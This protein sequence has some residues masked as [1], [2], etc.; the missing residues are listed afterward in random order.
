MAAATAAAQQQQQQ[1]QQHTQVLHITPTGTATTASP[2]QQSTQ[3]QLSPGFQG[4]VV[5]KP[6]TTHHHQA[7]AGTQQ[8]LLQN[9]QLIQPTIIG[10]QLLVPAGLSLMAPPSADAAGTTTLLQIQNVGSCTPTNILT[11]PG[12]TMMLR[13]TPPSPQA[14]KQFIQ[15]THAGSGATATAT[16]QQYILGSNGQL[17]PIGPLYSAAPTMSLMM[18]AAAANQA[19]GSGNTTFTL[20]RTTSNNGMATQQQ[21]TIIMQS[22]ANSTSAMLVNQQQQQQQQRTI[23]SPPDTTTHS[24]RSPERPPSHRSGGSDMVCT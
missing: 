22:P 7:T 6:T 16:S 18:P 24:P 14:N 13:A 5:N 4:I 3:F 15:G 20:Q 12:A 21:Q 23:A 8:I 10:Q 1:Q 2:Y 17:S 9:G 11:S 19:A